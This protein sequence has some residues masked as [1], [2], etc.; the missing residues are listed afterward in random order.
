M[1]ARARLT[2][3][4]ALLA[5]AVTAVGVSACGGTTRHA[6]RTQPPNASSSGRSHAVVPLTLGSAGR[7][8]PRGFLGLSMEFQ[9]V[10]AYTGDDPA[11]VNPVLEA[12][13]RNLDPGQS[14]VLRIGG[15]STDTS[16]VPAP[17]VTP[18]RFESY[19]ITPGWLAT[20]AALA[21]A[22]NAKMILGVNLAADEPALDAGEARAYLAAFGRSTIGALEIGNEPNLYA[23]IRQFQLTDGTWVTPRA[24]SFGPAGYEQ[25]IQRTIAALPRVSPAWSFAGPALAAGERAAGAGKWLAAVTGF[26]REQ[27]SVRV[28]TVHRYP[29]KHCYTGPSSPQYPTIAHLLSDYSTR[30]LADGVRR[31]VMLARAQG[32]T[33]R[34]DELNSVAC[35]GRAGVSNTFASALWAS[36]VLFSLANVGVGGVNVHTLPDSAYQLFTFTRHGRRWQGHVEP[37]YY[38][39][40]LF[41]QAAPAGSQ[42][43]GVTGAQHG[44]SLSTWATRAPDG[45]ERLL[46]IDKTPGDGRTVSV[47]MPSRA[48][49]PVSV[50][51]MT[52]PSLSARSSISLGGRSYGARTSS[53]TLSAPRTSGARERAGRVVV[54]LPGASA[55]LVTVQR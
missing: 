32:R 22:V 3:A 44:E 50:E 28:V 11:A 37:E 48:T 36:D 53:G 15:D 26:L 31:W 5:A 51:R 54:H 8:V 34:I 16:W 7:T 47:A 23:S 17:G 46:L 9:A 29:Q 14:P 43:V 12:L 38:G 20:T 25:E 33:V 30:E 27:P 42:L 55:A 13:I 4:T 21:H 39:L 1:G 2:T 24:H 41:A 52:A 35:R 10:R 18:P 6:A 49:G 45:T 19:T 40:Q